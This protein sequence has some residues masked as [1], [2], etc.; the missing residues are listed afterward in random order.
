MHWRFSHDASQNTHIT[1]R[2]QATTE[3]NIVKKKYKESWFNRNFTFSTGLLIKKSSESN[4]LPVKPIRCHDWTNIVCLWRH[5]ETYSELCQTSKT[6]RFAKI[7]N[8][9]RCG[10][11]SE[12]A[13]ATCYLELNSGNFSFF[14]KISWAFVI[15]LHI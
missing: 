2:I 15:V 7:V 1:P 14:K 9:F 10:K 13:S 12:Y 5:K 8:G 4:Y 6:E 11:C 3:L